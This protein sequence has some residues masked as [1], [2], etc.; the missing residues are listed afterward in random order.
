MEY[1]IDL[2]EWKEILLDTLASFIPVLIKALL[3]FIIGR[4]LIKRSM[5]LVKLLFLKKDWD[6]TLEKF[7]ESFIHAVLNI[8]LI[9]VLITTLGVQT[10]SLVAILGAASLAIGLALQGSL[11]NL[12]G[13]VLILLLKPFKVGEVIQAK[14]VSGTVMEVS[15][16]YTILKTFAGQRVTIPNGQITN[17]LV[18]NF[19]IYENRRM[20]WSFGIGYEDDI[21]KAKKILISIFEQEE[22][23]LKDPAPVVFLE[24]LADSSLNFRVRAWAT[25]D[26][27]WP[28]YN[29]IPEKVKKAFD[30]NGI[31]IPFPQR[32][33]HLYSKQP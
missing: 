11:S 22:N 2:N 23:V 3:I 25:L 33:V 20:D 6:E 29:S 18:T 27:Y 19:S 8:V 30:E 10:S 16:F 28:I 15:L 4:F 21:D 12:A 17:D 26:T 32:D 5:K 14:S 7:A 31:S 9:I 24:E 1:T 13:G